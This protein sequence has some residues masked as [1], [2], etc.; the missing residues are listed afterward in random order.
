MGNAAKAGKRKEE[1]AFS[2]VSSSFIGE[3]RG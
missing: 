1:T 3:N 2:V